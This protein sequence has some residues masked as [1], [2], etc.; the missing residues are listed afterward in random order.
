[1][2]RPEARFTP[3]RR[4]T[5]LAG[6]GAFGA[7]LVVLSTDDSDGRLLAAV[8]GVLLLGYVVC[9]LVFS[10]RLVASVDGVVVR[11]PLTRARLRWDEIEEVRADTRYHLGMRNT[12]LEIDAGATLAV[13]SRRAL[14]VDPVEAAELLEA[15]RP[16]H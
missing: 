8:A 13:L 14:G 10:P 4:L 3:D 9:D 12:L 6:G 16:P 15:F 5:A 11:S 2:T 7:L 1:V